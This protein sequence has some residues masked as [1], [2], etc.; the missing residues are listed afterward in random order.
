[1]VA[2][3]D[4]GELAAPMA[5]LLASL[6]PERVGAAIADLVTA[7]PERLR[8]GVTAH[9]LVEVL[10]GPLA[11]SSGPAAWRA[12][13]LVRAAVQEIVAGIPGMKYV[14]GDS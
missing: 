10:L 1:M 3:Q 5:V 13:L 14:E 12:R 2:D 11:Q 7:R 8:S 4:L 9:E 6:T